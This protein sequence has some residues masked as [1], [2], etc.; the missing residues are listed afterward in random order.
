MQKK[1]N[2][3]ESLQLVKMLEWTMVP[4]VAISYL[5]WQTIARS[6]QSGILK[7]DR[8]TDMELQNN[9]IWAAL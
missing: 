4:G 7:F 6:M 9:Y 1:N 5:P 2:Q 8:K 3:N